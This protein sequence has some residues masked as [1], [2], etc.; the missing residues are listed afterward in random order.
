MNNEE[1]EKYLR[2]GYE[3]LNERC[4]KIE[5][6]LVSYTP[7]QIIALYTH[8]KIELT[9]KQLDRVLY[10]KNGGKNVKKSRQTK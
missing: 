2:L 4:N 9:D 8:N 10:L 7:K 6:L 3:S 1:V 5:K